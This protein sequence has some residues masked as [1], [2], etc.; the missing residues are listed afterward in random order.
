MD[1]ARIISGTPIHADPRA[2][3]PKAAV[4]PSC[5]PASQIQGSSCRKRIV[6]EKQIHG[7]WGGCD[8]DVRAGAGADLWIRRRPIK[9]GAALQ[10]GGCNAWGF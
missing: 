4:T 7:L 6:A 2:V 8:V 10:L 9:F 5:G 3:D 1:E